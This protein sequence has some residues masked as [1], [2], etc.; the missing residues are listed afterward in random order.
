MQRWLILSLCALV[1]ACSESETPDGGSSI[2][3]PN[4]ISDAGADLGTV[5]PPDMGT[6]DQGEPDL[7]TPDLGEPDMGVEDMGNSACDPLMETGCMLPWPSNLYLEPDNAR[8]TGMTL[9]FQRD[10]LPK[11]GG[12]VAADPAPYR[13]L[14]GYGV[15]TS[16]I[17]LFEN[18]D[19]SGMP[20]ETDIGASLAMDAQILWYEVSP[21]G[22]VRVPYFA[23]L[24]SQETDPASRAL[25]VRPAVIL[26]ENTRY[27]V[28]FRDLQDLSGNAIAVSS[29]FAALRDG[30]T[31]QDPLLAPRQ[32]RF[33]QIFTQLEGEGVPRDSLVL[34]W[35]FHTASSEGLHGPMLHMRDEALALAPMGPTLRIDS[36]EEFAPTDDGSGLPVNANI[37]LDIEATMVAPNYLRPKSINLVNGPVLNLGADGLPEQ[38]GTRDV[39]VWIRVPHSAVTTTVAHGLVQYGH[40]LLGSGDQVRGS[41]NSKIANDHQMIFFAC[42]LFGFAEEDELRAGL[43]ALEIGHFEWLADSQHQGLLDYLMLARAMREQFA[44]LPQ[45]AA[46]NISVDANALYYSGISQGGIFGASYMALSTDITRGHLGVPGQNYGNLLLHRSVDFDPFLE[47]V[48]SAYVPTLDQALALGIIEQLWE[49]VEPVSYYRHLSEAP[50]AGTPSHEVLAAPAKGDYQVSVL[51]MEVVARTGLGVPLMDNYDDERT[52]FSAPLQSYPHQGSGIVLYDFGNPWPPAGNRTPMDGLGDPHGLPR[53]SDLHNMQ[54]IH[55]FRTGEIIDVCGG[56]GCNP[57]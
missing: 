35:D 31:A 28:A 27:I 34:A 9:A 26:K 13:R 55:F 8:V 37:A 6:P 25:L 53:R 10:A 39:R 2:D 36:I 49:A 41:F 29:A 42:D 3:I 30:Q 52:V 38:D 32:A 4:V 46:R 5:D 45:I 15:G 51:S 11:N 19:A 48:R 16:A 12:G 43:S 18:L 1:G 56:D 22:L 14:D 23:E 17:V 21:N 44:A 20:D 7:G 33:D 40:G 54:M 47:Q 50:F 24:D 57:D